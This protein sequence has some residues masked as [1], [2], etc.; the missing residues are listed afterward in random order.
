MRPDALSALPAELRALPQWVCANAVKHP[1]DPHSGRAAK[2]NKPATWGTLAEAVEAAKRYKLPHVGFVL[3]ESDPYCIVDLD[4]KP[5]KP[6]SDAERE[7]FD[8]II[9]SLDS[10]TESSRGGRGYHIIV[11]AR[12]PRALKTTHVE[13]YDRAR[14]MI[15]TGSVTRGALVNGATLPDR[16]DAVN[17]LCAQYAPRKLQQVEP[18]TAVALPQCS[19]AEVLMHCAR[20]HGEK[21]ETL[22][23]GQWIGDYRSESEAR[24][25]LFGMFALHSPDDAQVK[26]LLFETPL[27]Q[28]EKA[29]RLVDYELAKIRANAISHDDDSAVSPTSDKRN[30]QRI[31]R[32]MGGYLMY[33]PGLGWHVWDG[34]RW[35]RNKDEARRLVQKELDRIVQNEAVQLLLLTKADEG[36]ADKLRKLSD[37]LRKHAGQSGNVNKI[38]AAMEAAETLVCVKLDKLDADPMF[39]G[40]KN[41][42]L[43]LRTG[44]LLPPDPARLITQ[45]TGIAFDPAAECHAWNAFLTRIFRSH[46]ELVPFAQRLAGYWLT[47][48][49]D[50]ALLAV[51]YG[52]G[53]NGKSTFTGA[54]M[55]AL[56]EY[57]APA[58]PR[59]LMATYGERHPTELASLQG[60]RLVVAAESGEGG[61]LDEEKIKALTGSDLISARRMRE[62]LFTFRPTHKLAL[63]TNH[64]PMVRG[65]DEGIWRRLLLIPFEEII[66][67]RERD[68]SLSDKLRREAGG[69]LAWAVQGC[70]AF[71]RDGLQ[72]PPVVTE[73]TRSYRS[74]NDVLAEFLSDECEVDAKSIVTSAELYV[75]YEAWTEASGERALSRKTLGLRL[76]ERG[77]EKHMNRMG[78]RGWRGLRLKQFDRP[79]RKF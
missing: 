11:K 67:E 70:A 64:K 77:F 5:D 60:R 16:Q 31:Q 27:G 40:C 10:Y 76:Q 42:V 45:S 51:L 68:A 7:A 32:H 75:R 41:G 55:H 2:V 49:T 72:P 61:R 69:I 47:G 29:Q 53:A 63:M 74:E 22:R 13:I 57:A 43:D 12:I 1:I 36:I 78:A 37:T 62:D 19:D 48:R 15:C 26:R 4:D 54:L 24:F 20:E 59:L 71:Q 44:E 25:A 23:S 79:A 9:Q 39:L 6:A 17:A 56:G 28:S 58:P 35:E 73:A 66:P 8:S 34:S 3:T 14:Y 33:V 46:P 52:V 30:G 50:P 21:F 18:S 38:K 65:T